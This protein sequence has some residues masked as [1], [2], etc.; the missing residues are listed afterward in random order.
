M[1]A[2]PLLAMKLN[3]GLFSFE[4]PGPD[5]VVPAMI[6][7]LGT[8]DKTEPLK[9]GPTMAKTKPVAYRRS[10]TVAVS[11]PQGD[12]E[13]AQAVER[14]LGEVAQRSQNATIKVSEN[15]DF[16]GKPA[17]WGELSYKFGQ[18]PL[19]TLVFITF[20][21]QWI[22]TA[23]AIGL[24]VKTNDKAMRAWMNGYIESLASTAS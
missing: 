23:V 10:F 16:H 4:L 11:L 21:D 7:L 12:E 18:T 24:D 8:E 15:R 14:T 17:K 2:C 13:P 6:T 3:L 1:I 9:A 19:R 5:P 20:V 22:V